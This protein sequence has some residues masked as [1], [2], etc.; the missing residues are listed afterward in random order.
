MSAHALSILL[1]PGSIRQVLGD[2]GRATRHHLMHEPSMQALAVRGQFPILGSQS[3]A[4]RL[5]PLAVLPGKQPL[6]HSS[7]LVVVQ[8]VVGPPLPVEL[9]LQAA[10]GLL[11]R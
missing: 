1:L 8:R 3:A 9:A 5:V 10:L 4:R 6:A 7:L 2:D 11:I